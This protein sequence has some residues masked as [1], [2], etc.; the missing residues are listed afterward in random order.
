MWNGPKP[1]DWTYVLAFRNTKWQ[2]FPGDLAGSSYA[3]QEA[4][5]LLLTQQHPERETSGAFSRC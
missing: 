2:C 1:A 4:L 5:N 3:L